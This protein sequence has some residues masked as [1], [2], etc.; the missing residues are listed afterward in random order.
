MTQ[1]EQRLRQE[2]HDMAQRLA[3]A[4]L[5]PLREPPARGWSARARWLVPVAAASAV[6]SV[7]LGLWLAGQPAGHRPASPK[8]SAIAASGLPGYYV[9]L[10]FGGNRTTAVVADSVTGKTLTTVRVPGEAENY[11]PQVAAAADDRTFAILTAA[12]RNRGLVLFRLHVAADGRSARLGRVPVKPFTN[13]VGVTG[14]ALSPDGSQFATAREFPQEILVT[15]LA[16]GVTRIW[17]TRI[18]GIP[19]Q[20]A[21][22][23]HGS[24]V[25]FVWGPPFGSRS[26]LMQVRVLDVARPGSDLLAG[27]VIANLRA[28]AFGSYDLTP[29]ALI[30][31]D[32]RMI[33]ASELQDAFRGGPIAGTVGTFRFVELS[34]RTGRIVRVLYRRR[35]R[36]TQRQMLSDFSCAVMSLGP[37]G[38]QPLVECP[39][40][41]RLAGDTITWLPGHSTLFLGNYA[42]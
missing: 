9:R 7:A 18:A 31:P 32:G 19:S 24:Q 29:S 30:T 23:D 12:G 27:R 15:S 39:R 3:P 40:V 6:A 22:V 21:W 2:L 34:T 8:P 10:E 35:V 42:W 26:H 5:R 36:F 4:D 16:T 17:S 25:G 38:V 28:P 1:L 20:P 41:G 14:V 11:L 33:I 13:Y 37:V